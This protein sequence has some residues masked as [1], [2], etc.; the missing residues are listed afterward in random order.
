M[1]SLLRREDDM[2]VAGECGT[3]EEAVAQAPQLCPDVVIMDVALPGMT[4]V[5]AT[6]LI[7][8]AL[9]HTRIVALSNHSGRSL[10]SAVLKAGGLGYVRKDHAFE[11]LVPAIRSVYAGRRFLGLDIDD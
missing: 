6:R 7:A 10:V 1:C 2:E 5:E 3:G 4:G 11:E 9:P 8:L